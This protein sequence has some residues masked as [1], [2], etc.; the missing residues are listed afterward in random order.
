MHDDKLRQAAI[1][2]AYE[3]KMFR[4]A[5]NRYLMS[6]LPTAAGVQ[7][8]HNDSRAGMPLTI[9]AAA[10]APSSHYA[11]YLNRDALL[12]H[13]RILGDFF[14]KP[15]DEDDI[16]AHHYRGGG[17]RQPPAWSGDFNKKC[18]KL[19]AHLTY[20]RAE[21]RVRDEH[22]WH[23]VPGWTQDI[24]VDITQFLESLTAEQRNW[25]QVSD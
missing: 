14:Y 12:I 15:D 11:A 23:E 2:V 10:G 16:R 19:F 3:F 20:R 25:F 13:I 1:D 9:S 22:H 17:P 4:E 18:N 24:D 6:V 5:R 8:G 21:Y 7:L